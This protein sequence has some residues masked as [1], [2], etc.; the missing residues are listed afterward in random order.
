MHWSYSHSEIADLKDVYEYVC[1]LHKSQFKQLGLQLGLLLPT[2]KRITDCIKTQNYGMELM[3]EWLKQ[4]DNAKPTWNNLA[5]ALDKRTVKGHVQAIQIREYL[6]STWATHIHAHASLWPTKLRI[7]CSTPLSFMNS[8]CTCNW[9]LAQNNMQYA[10][11]YI[12]YCLQGNMIVT[13]HSQELQLY[14][15][16]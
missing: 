10:C 15:Y 13:N 6:K 4:V 8:W 9:L 5:K 14:H 7:W 3:T 11:T 2:L 1:E 12:V 16:H